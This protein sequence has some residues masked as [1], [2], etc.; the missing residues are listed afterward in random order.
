MDL[1]VLDADR[2]TIGVYDR[3]ESVIWSRRWCECGE[4]EVYAPLDAEA[5]ALFLSGTYVARDDDPMVGVIESVSTE[6]DEDEGRHLTVSGRCAKCLLERRVIW[7]Q[8][9]FSG[10][11]EQR[12]R[13]AVLANAVEPDDPDRAIP[14]LRLGDYAAL[15]SEADSQATGDNLME[16]VSGWLSADGLGWSVELDADRSLVLSVL[17]GVDRSEGQSETPRVAFAP[18]LDNLVSSEFELDTAGSANV[19]LVGGEGEGADRTYATAGAAS[20]LERRE[21]FVDARGTSSTVDEGELGAD[22]YLAVLADKG[23][24]ELAG[25]APKRVFDGVISDGGVFAL[26]V[27]YFLGDIVSVRDSAGISGTTRIVG[28]VECEDPEGRTVEPE[29][30]EWRLPD[31]DN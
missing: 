13:S 23:R 10:T 4:F 21:T 12:V 16:A 28:V 15:G 6:T 29:L 24:S 27:D 2:N 7:G 25:K 3:A 20:G 18:D 14:G 11:A 19:A 5:A 22:E 31:G 9:T 30:E 17:E 1:Y 26:G 8:Q